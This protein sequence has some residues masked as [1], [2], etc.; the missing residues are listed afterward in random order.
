MRP[1]R[2]TRVA[3]R[4]HAVEVVT[5]ASAEP[6]PRGYPIR[7]GSRSLPPGVRHARVAWLIRSAARR[8]DVVYSTGMPG[9]SAVGSRLARTPLV[10]RLTGDPV[11][12]RALQ[13]GLTRSSLVDFQ[14]EGGQKVGLLRW[15][16]DRSI[17]RAARVLCPSAALRD[18][19][20]GWG[21]DPAKI[22]VLPHALDVPDPGERR[23]LRARLGFQGTTLVYA[24]RLVRRRRSTS[25]CARWRRP[26]ASRSSS[27]AKA[28]RARAE[29]LVL[30]LGLDERVRFVGAQPRGTVLQLFRA[31][32]ATLLSSGWESFGLVVAESLAL[33]TP[34]V[35]TAVGGVVELV[36]DGRNGLL[37]A[38][39]DSAALAAAIGRFFAS[40]E[41]PARL[42]AAAAASV[43]RFTPAVVYGG[44]SG[45]CP[46][47][48]RADPTGGRPLGAS[49]T[50]WKL[51]KIVPGAGSRRWLEVRSI[52]EPSVWSSHTN[53]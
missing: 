41:L 30:E 26:K 43:E 4:G 5:T 11:Y 49:A 24:G 21:V 39:G 1:R 36:E 17:E 8:A 32:D 31:A 48:R 46:N 33:G 15:M 35:S 12:E 53:G 37:A 38:V 6:D 14:H 29:A 50:T 19:A 10:L 44:W 28:E 3:A 20:V 23:E 25:A 9:R 27:P 45:S 34:V 18:V 16:R 42:R 47:G 2:P 52:I 51:A 13:H 7:W 22:E 40:I